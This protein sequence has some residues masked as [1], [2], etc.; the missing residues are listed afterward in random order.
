[1]VQELRVL[2]AD[3]YNLIRAL[4]REALI[5]LGYP[6]ITEASNGVEAYEKLTQAHAEGNGFGLVFIDWNMPQM[7][8]IELLQK[9]KSEDAFKEIPFIMITAERDK[10]NIMMALNAGVADYV[11]KPFSPKQVLLKIEKTLARCKVA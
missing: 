11:V 2:V 5:E 7:T 1:M 3:D 10:K 6:N 8:G 4:L 9:C